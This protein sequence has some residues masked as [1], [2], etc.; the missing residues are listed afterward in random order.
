MAK[1]RLSYKLA[2]ILLTNVAGSTALVQKD[3]QPAHERIPDA[4]KC[5]S[6]TIE[7]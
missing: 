2:V 5:L 6:D 4:F 3:E 7:K 1:D